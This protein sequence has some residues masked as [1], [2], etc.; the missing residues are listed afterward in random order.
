[1]T[2]ATMRTTGRILGSFVLLVSVAMAGSYQTGKLLSVT[3]ASS[4]RDVGT[5]SVTDVE[6]RLSVQ[7][8][9]MIYVGSY[10]PRWNWSYEPTEFIVNDPI[11]VRI[12]GKHMY[13]KRGSGKDLKT[14]I[15]Q[16][17]R[18]KPDLTAR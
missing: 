5:I 8:G 3:D 4:N 11:E 17:V 6:Y 15:I 9:E 14:N 13:I 10:W 2:Y 1:M 16:R 18:A 7:V 12:D